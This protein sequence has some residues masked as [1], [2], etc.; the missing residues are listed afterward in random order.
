MA[1]VTN[2]I[3]RIRTTVRRRSMIKKR[4]EVN[5]PIRDVLNGIISL[6]GNDSMRL[7]EDE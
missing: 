2:S 6:I 5:I 4:K 3:S 7:G 1:K